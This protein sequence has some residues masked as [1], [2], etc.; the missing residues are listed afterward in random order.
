MLRGLRM[1]LAA[2]VLGTMLQFWTVAPVQALVSVELQTQ[3]EAVMALPADQVGAALEALIKANSGLAVDIAA[4]AVT[5]NKDL[6]GVIAAAAVRAAPDQAVDIVVAIVAIA[7]D[8]GAEVIAAIESIPGVDSQV[9]ASV[10]GVIGDGTSPST[11][12]SGTAENPATDD[13]SP[14]T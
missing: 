9:V 14:T 13:S 8:S 5:I 3:I 6:A 11:K 7:T 12:P 10:K 1:G 4:A 2:A